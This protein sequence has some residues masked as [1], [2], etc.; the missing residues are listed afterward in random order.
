MAQNKS[1]RSHHYRTVLRWTGNSGQGTASYQSYTRN[2]VVDAI[3]RP[4][5]QLASDPAFRGDTDRWNPELLLLAAASSCHQLWYLHCCAVGGVT[6]TAYRDAAEA[7]MVEEADGGGQFSDIVLRPE[8]TIAAGSDPD[9][10]RRLHH[11][12]NEKCFIARSLKVIIRHE[13]TIIVAT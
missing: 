5:L 8:V 3:D 2:H 7:V 9:T 12:A 6:V 1:G 13:P 10:A 4:S 11:D